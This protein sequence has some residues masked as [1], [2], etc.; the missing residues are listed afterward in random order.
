MNVGEWFGIKSLWSIA[1]NQHIERSHAA[2]D[3]FSRK[4]PW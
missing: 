3:T 1:L 2:V 4:M